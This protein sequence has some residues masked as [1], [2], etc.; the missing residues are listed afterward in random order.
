M[1]LL[2]DGSCS[3][4]RNASERL[5]R[6]AAAGSVERLSFREPGVLDRFPQ[7]SAAACEQAM[8]LVL[9]DGRVISGA[10]SAFRIL[11]TRWYFRPALWLYLVPGIRHGVDAM[12]RL[13][14]R[15][16]HRLGGGSTTT[17]DTGACGLRRER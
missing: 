6:W 4:C 7:V 17:C 16:R 2:Y 5:V 10:E 3:L 1:V 12:Y 13:I 11:A 9:D 14:A 15:N 8:Q